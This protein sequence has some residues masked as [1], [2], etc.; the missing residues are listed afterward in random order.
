MK[1]LKYFL[2]IAFLINFSHV[3]IA[4]WQP[5][6]VNE[7][8][9]A[10]IILGIGDGVLITKTSDLHFG[11]IK[12]ISGSGGAIAI[13]PQYGTVT[14]LSGNFILS[15]NTSIATF[16]LQGPKGKKD[17]VYTLP[18]NVVLTSAQGNTMTVSDMTVYRTPQS[19]QAG[20]GEHIGYGQT[21]NQGK[22]TLFVGGT[23]NINANQPN[24]VYSN[25]TDLKVVVIL[26]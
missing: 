4:Q 23:L 21:N 16:G 2:S 1:T 24:G 18:T 11:D 17:Y 5:G 6:A 15:G 19:G 13:N 9:H 12:P 22:A 10:S 14:I 7:T 3:A 26:Q 25:T 8:G 20:L